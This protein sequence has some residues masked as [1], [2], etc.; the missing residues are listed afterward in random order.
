MA[1][2]KLDACLTCGGDVIRV[3]YSLQG[4]KECQACG[5]RFINRPVINNY[6][7]KNAISHIVF[8]AT[9]AI[10]YGGGRYVQQFFNGF[11]DT[12]TAFIA[13]SLVCAAI[14]VPVVLIFGPKQTD[15]EWKVYA[16]SKGVFERRD[17]KIVTVILLAALL[18]T[19][20]LMSLK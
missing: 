6:S 14:L 1:L 13:A 7:K 8:I 18:G 19:L 11:W 20:L 2:Q 15:R 10:V 3:R 17:A 5:V 4:L 12:T 16:Q 9:F